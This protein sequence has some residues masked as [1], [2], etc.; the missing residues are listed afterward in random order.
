MPE[1]TVRQ[2]FER[3]YGPIPEDATCH[4]GYHDDSGDVNWGVSVIEY[5]CK[6]NPHQ[7]RH[8]HYWDASD[9]QWVSAFEDSQDPIPAQNDLSK[10]EAKY[11]ENFTDSRFD[12]ALWSME[13]ELSGE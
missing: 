3:A 10:Y 13:K 9:E 8:L 7:Y 4:I 2:V 11:Y 5:L 12:N 1:P 6:N